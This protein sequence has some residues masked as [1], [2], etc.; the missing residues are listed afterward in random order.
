M[1]SS[2]ARSCEV[3]LFE[4]LEPGHRA[5]EVERPEVVAAMVLDDLVG[6]HVGFAQ[7]AL[8]RQAG[9]GCQPGLPGGP[10]AAFAGDDPP[11]LAFVVPTCTRSGCRMPRAAMDAASRSSS[12]LHPHPPGLVR[13]DHQFIDRHLDEVAC[14]PCFR[15]LTACVPR[16]EILQPLAD[17]EVEFAVGVAPLLFPRS[18]A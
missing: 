16:L 2:A 3:Q 17:H 8:D 14:S 18:T 15:S 5:G 4:P 11:A 10:P 9:H 13:V 6:E 7:L 1:P 12:D